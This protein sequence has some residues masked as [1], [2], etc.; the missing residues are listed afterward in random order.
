MLLAKPTLE[1][2]DDFLFGSVS[3]SDIDMWESLNSTQ[4]IYPYSRAQILPIHGR[5]MTP[6]YVALFI[7]KAWNK[8]FV[9]K[10]SIPAC[11]EEAMLYPLTLVTVH[12][13]RYQW[14]IEPLSAVQPSQ[15]RNHHSHQSRFP[16]SLV[17]R[18]LRGEIS[19]TKARHARPGILCYRRFN[20]FRN[21]H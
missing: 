6:P 17:E 15:I 16:P 8:R 14:P 2:T 5:Y 21:I 19:T 3:F 11:N 9:F 20:N 7:P 12:Q 10:T 18:P 13:R 1:T 4:H